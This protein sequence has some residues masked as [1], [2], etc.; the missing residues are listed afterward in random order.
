M[1][2]LGGG[3]LIRAI[4]QMRPDVPAILTSGFSDSMPDRER[5]ALDLASFLQ[6]PY[7]QAELASHIAAALSR[8][9]LTRERRDA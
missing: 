1:P 8:R 3:G 9:G 7:T 5:A 4:H 2:G 6:K